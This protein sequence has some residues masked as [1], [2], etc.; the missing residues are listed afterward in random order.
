MKIQ[1]KKKHPSKFVDFK[2]GMKVGD[3]SSFFFFL[4][5]FF[6]FCEFKDAFSHS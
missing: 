2:A 4:I 5:L 3:L 1:K 6:Y